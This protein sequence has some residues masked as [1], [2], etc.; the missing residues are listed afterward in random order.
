MLPAIDTMPGAWYEPDSRNARSESFPMMPLVNAVLF[1]SFKSALDDWPLDVPPVL[2][3]PVFKPP[4]FLPIVK[5]AVICQLFDSRFCAVNSTPRY[6]V[7]RY[8]SLSTM[9]FC[10]PVNV[11]FRL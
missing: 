2:M 6:F 11:G 7:S 4:V 3:P 1:G 8:G 10:K 9:L 5:P